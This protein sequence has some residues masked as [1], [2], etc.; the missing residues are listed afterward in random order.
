MYKVHHKRAP[1]TFQNIFTNNNE[2][3]N[4]RTRGLN[5]LLVPSYKLEIMKQ[6]IRV[7]GVYVWNFVCSHVSSTC[8]IGVFKNNLRK[9]L[10]V[11]EQI[12]DIIP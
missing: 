1:E 4:H 11:N 5:K 9:F 8:T 6:S 2:I 3:H 12:S 10:A 7:K